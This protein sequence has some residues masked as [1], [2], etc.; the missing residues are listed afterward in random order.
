MVRYVPLK[1]LC[2]KTGYVRITKLWG[3]F[4]QS[5]L[6]ERKTV[7]IT[8]PESVFVALGIEHAMR[9]RHIVICVPSGSTIFFYIV[10]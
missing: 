6:H 4:V 2:N 1:L 10:S 7:S 5:L 3:V 9:M 8:N